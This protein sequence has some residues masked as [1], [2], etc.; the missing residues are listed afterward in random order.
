[1]KSVIKRRAIMAVLML[2]GFASAG[3]AFPFNGSFETPTVADGT[4]L[5]GI[6]ANWLGDP[7]VATKNPGGGDALQP[8]D[9]NNYAWFSEPNGKIWQWV[10]G[11]IGCD[12]F[13]W[14]S[15]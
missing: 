11:T 2:L 14:R 10:A 3:W 4:S 15:K 13:F 1:M 7:C 12:K 5:V 6:P 8:T 9:G